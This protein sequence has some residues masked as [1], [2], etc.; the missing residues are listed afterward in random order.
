MIAPSS[1]NEASPQIGDVFKIGLSAS[2]LG[3]GQIID[4]YKAKM[5]LVA[6]FDVQRA[7]DLPVAIEGVL[8]SSAIFVCNTLDALLWHGRWQVIGQV[9]PDH[10]RFPL[11]NY[12]VDIGGRLMVENFGATKARAAT[13]PELDL[14]DFRTCYAPIGVENALKA[15][16]GLQPW[17]DRFDAL[18]ACRPLRG[19]RINVA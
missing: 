18:R 2:S 7:A 4:T 19:A 1:K 13:P 11:P 17:E 15:H 6:I 14:L 8:A 10:E 16:F 12:K 5:L 9:P 3:F